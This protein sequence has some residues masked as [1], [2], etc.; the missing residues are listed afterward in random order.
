[1]DCLI[2]IQ[3][4]LITLNL[5]SCTFYGYI[6]KILLLWS[7]ERS[8]KLS[9]YWKCQLIGWCVAS[10]YWG[11]IGFSGAHF[12]WF[13]G[14]LQFITDVVL[15]IAITHLYRQFVL[16]YGWQHLQ[17]G[18]LLKRIIPAILFMAVFYTVVTCLK[19]WAF[20]KLFHVGAPEGFSLF[21][22]HNLLNVFMAGIRLM[23]IWIL[24]YHLYQYAQREIRAVKENSRLAL[25]NRDA[26]LAHLSSQIHPHF[27]FNAL[28]TIKSLVEEDPRAARHG[29]DLLSSLLR[30][31][32]EDG[33]DLVPLSK[34][35]EL[36]RDYL[37]LEKLRFEERLQSNFN[38]DLS[39][40][41]VEI[42][43]LAVQTLIE[44]AIKHGIATLKNG[45][46]VTVDIE[47]REKWMN[48][49]ISNLGSLHVDYRTKGLGFKN[50]VE[51]LKLTY[52]AEASLQLDEAKSG[53]VTATLN[54]PLI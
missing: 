18:P 31:G 42:P 29:I 5:R 23:S 32:L 8:N 22:S 46:T 54:I 45:G 47:R 6:L 9:L 19:I 3:T 48:I 49:T 52:G 38:I 30:S 37:D 27:L 25:I 33:A 39:L 14:V 41:R 10:L 43:K 11:Y 21:L 7:M 40:M 44:N 51:R 36:V 4:A 53:Q 24:A 20:K 1:M 15:Y 26:S 28:N 2:L 35:M 17:L 13:I 16:H 50:L 12:S 34:E